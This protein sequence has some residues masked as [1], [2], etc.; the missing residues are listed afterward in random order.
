[1]N[2]L[3]FALTGTL[4]F[5]SAF[6]ASGTPIIPSAT[7]D[8]VKNTAT[9][10][11]RQGTLQDGTKFWFIL[12]DASTKVAATANGLGYSPSLRAAASAKSTRHVHV[13][14]LGNFTFDHGTVDFSPVRTIIPGDAPNFFPPKL[15][16][17]G[18]IAS[19]DYS[20]F[21]VADDT[22]GTVYNAPIIATGLPLTQL[23][24]ADG[25]PDYTLVHDK[26]ISIDPAKSLVVLQLTH[27]F[28]DSHEIVYFS[29]DASI[30]LAATLEAATLAPAEA[31]LLNSGVALDLYAFANGATG[32]SNPDRQGFDSALAGEGSPLNILTLPANG[33]VYS[34]LWS[35]NVG[36]WTPSAIAN[37]DRK[38]ITNEADV[39]AA[40]QAGLVTNPDGTPLSEAGFLVNCPI[41]QVLGL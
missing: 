4:F 29:F 39:L 36:A 16:T 12:T 1:M 15:A 8:L 11:L 28:T 37:G 30:G 34:P 25:T 6:A 27:G 9:L 35:V 21:A 7:I 18:S 20:P 26:V 41:V 10:P 14:P 5:S 38:R 23:L 22:A 31:D 32:A 19:S 17:P 13:D 3:I 33:T 24:N 40:A 2:S